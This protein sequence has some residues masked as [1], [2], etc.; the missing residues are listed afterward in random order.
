[1]AHS[2]SAVRDVRDLGLDERAVRPTAH[3]A[4][5][6]AKAP[7]PFLIRIRV[8]LNCFA[9]V[10]SILSEAVPGGGDLLA[11]HLERVRVHDVLGDIFG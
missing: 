8:T 11:V 4:A 10:V 7:K 6:L 2:S 3:D 5:H 9:H 1:M